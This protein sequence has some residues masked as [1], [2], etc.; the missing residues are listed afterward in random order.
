[1]VIYDPLAYNSRPEYYIEYQADPDEKVYQKDWIFVNGRL[2]GQGMTNPNGQGFNLYLD[3]QMIDEDGEEVHIMN[4]L[5]T[6]PTMEDLREFV[7]SNAG[8]LM[9]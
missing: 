5:R 8:T 7:E 4:K 2:L 9:S 3:K 1:M 6:F